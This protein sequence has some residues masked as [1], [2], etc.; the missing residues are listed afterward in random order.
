MALLLKNRNLLMIFFLLSMSVFPLCAQLRLGGELGVN[1]SRLKVNGAGLVLGPTFGLTADYTLQ[2]NIVL[3]SGLSVTQKGGS[4]LWSNP[5]YQEELYQLAWVRNYYLELPLMVGYKFHLTDGIALS[6]FVGG[7]VACGI[8]GF[9]EIEE[10]TGMMRMHPSWYGTFSPKELDYPEKRTI[11][12]FNRWD[13]GL[14]F[15]L[16]ADVHRFSFNVIY[17]MGFA[18]AWDGFPGM[19]DFDFYNRNFSITLGYHFSL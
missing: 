8:G 7:Y 9:G 1:M 19:Y 14:R 2:S 17:N 13:G 10:F 16:S 11:P 6:S 4:D 5:N 15:G 18:K 12:A 3:K